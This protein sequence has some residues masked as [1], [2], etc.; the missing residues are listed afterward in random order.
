MTRRAVSAPKLVTSTGVVFNDAVVIVEN[1]QI[2]AVG[3]LAELQNQLDGVPTS[4]F[5]DATILPGLIDAHVH[6]TLPGDGRAIEETLTESD[7]Y[8]ALVGYQNVRTH[9]ASGVTTMRDNGA[10]GE[11]AY[12][13]R[14]Y[15]EEAA[16]PTPR[17]LVS[18]PPI[19]PTGGHMHWWGGSADGCDDVRRAVRR[20][21]GEG[22]DHIK[23]VASG[24]GTRGTLPDGVAFSEAELRFA[25]EAAHDLGR[26]TT[27]HAHA[28]EGIRR[29]AR[30]GVDCIEHATFITTSGDGGRSGGEYRD[31][32]YTQSG[33]VS[34]F[35]SE[36]AEEVAKAG[37][38][39]SAT[40]LGGYEDLLE[41]GRR[42]DELTESERRRLSAAEE[43]V[44]R[45]LHAFSSLV[46][47]GFTGK[48]VVSTDAGPATMR[49]GRLQLA[50]EL[51]VSGGLS[52]LQAI[53]AATRVAAE[54][55]GIQSEV[56]TLEP[57]KRADILVVAGDVSVDIAALRNILAVFV[58]GVGTSETAKRI[59][60]SES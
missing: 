44:E 25:V 51:A 57:G 28:T 14:R 60:I 22:A 52:P 37:C 8:L 34:R 53:E 27:V 2:L 43:H 19:T 59:A 40:L 54:A 6:V 50:L 41:L 36:V 46:E 5:E 56:G 11:T 23:L 13:V 45:K 17:L 48:L 7:A 30:A 24:G 12:G 26:L 31:A 58:A 15:L 29:A 55:C 39:V 42:R 20:R 18:G 38:F 35:D 16:T 4:R 32:M 10:R 33:L 1:G 21:V 49:F 9:L 3:A 47:H